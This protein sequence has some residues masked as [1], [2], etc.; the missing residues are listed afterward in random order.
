MLYYV[1]AFL[2]NFKRGG[3]ERIGVKELAKTMSS[4]QNVES[5]GSKPGP[6]FD[7]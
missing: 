1:K 2:L 4:T 6:E 3:V 5:P 7:F